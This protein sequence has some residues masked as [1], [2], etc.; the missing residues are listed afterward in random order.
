[1]IKWGF[2]SGMQRFLN[3]CKSMWYPILT[4]WRI[5]TIDPILIAAEK[6][7]NKS[8]TPTYDRNSLESRHRRSIPQNSKG[9]TQQA[10]R[11]IILKWWKTESISSKIR[12]KTRIP[13]F[14][15]IIQHTS[16]S[17]SHSNQRR[18]I[19]KRNPD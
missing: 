15:T 7:F 13:N 18:K 17:S 5:K 11:N 8:P 16:G 10:S 2:I 12:S 19:N 6:A 3:M 14:T 4:N 1:M 9:H